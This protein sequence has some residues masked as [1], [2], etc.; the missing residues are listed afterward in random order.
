MGQLASE[1]IGKISEEDFLRADLYDLLAALLSGPPSRDLID[2]VSRLT[3]DDGDLGR[4]VTAL[5]RIA[6]ATTAK[7]AESEFNS[8]FVGLG[9]GELLPYASYYMTGFLHEKPLAMLRNEMRR[10]GI[11]RAPNVYEPEDNIASLCEMM[12]GLI[13]GRFEAGQDLTTQRD[14]FN[15][16]LG[17]W[18]GHFFAD[19]EGAKG[20]VFYAPVGAIGRIFMEIEREA[21]R[22]SA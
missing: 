11:E 6:R 7:A 16:H 17:P 15:T 18:G 20:S 12:A 8:L 19:L 2:R 4:A 5:A 1:G 10:L 14:F 3:G 21:F 22:M 9:R 13:R